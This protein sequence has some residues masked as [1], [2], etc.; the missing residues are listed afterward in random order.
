MNINMKLS[1]IIRSSQTELFQYLDILWAGNISL[2]LELV[3]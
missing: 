2:R 1:L 3:L